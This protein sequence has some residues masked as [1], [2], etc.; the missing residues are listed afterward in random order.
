[1]LLPVLS[2][3]K[4]SA[5]SVACMNNLKQLQLCC[6]LYGLDNNDYLVPNNSVA[7]LSTG[8][9]NASSN[10]K[11]LSWLPD[12]D[13]RTEIDPSNIV[14]GLLFQ[15]NTALGIYHCPADQSQ[16]EDD[17]GVLLPQSRWRSYNMSQS[18]NGYPEGDT[19]YFGIIPTW[20]K[21]TQIRHPIP[22][23]FFVFVDEHSDTEEDAEFGCPPIGGVFQEYVWWD[24]PA[25]RH[26]RGANLSFADGHVEY[27]KWA[28]PKVFVYFGQPVVSQEMPDYQRIRAAMK[29]P[30]DN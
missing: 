27:W 28:F 19:V 1:M 7:I 9:S 15:Y 13:A 11:G 20:E 30:A 24:M 23:E 6:H 3:T 22:S 5:Q 26:S 2:R 10:I 25:D 21:F 14:N 4:G 18:A 16:L 8:T 17:N 29:Q 12:V